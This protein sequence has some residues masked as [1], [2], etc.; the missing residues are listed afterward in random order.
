MQYVIGLVGL[1]LKAKSY[2]D[3]L[4]GGEKQRVAIARALVNDPKLII[5]DEPTGNIDPELSY[6]IVNLLREINACGTT[7]LMVTH[8]HEMVRHF[9]GRIINIT[10]G[11]IVYDEIIGGEDESEWSQISD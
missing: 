6:E 11:E 8:E 7:I 4:S 10:D 3:E 2:P 1:Q 9:G 5:A